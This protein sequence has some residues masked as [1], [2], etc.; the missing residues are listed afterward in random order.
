MAGD[1]IAEFLDPVPGNQP[2]TDSPHQIAA[3][4]SRLL[5]IV[6]DDQLGACYYL[7]VDFALIPVIRAGG[8]DQSW[9]CEPIAIQHRDFG[10]AGS[11]DDIDIDDGSGG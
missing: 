6:G 1:D 7:A 5:S 8:D 9:A 10:R 4:R 2:V 3:F 11:D